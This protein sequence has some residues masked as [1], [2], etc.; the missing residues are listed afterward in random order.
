VFAGVCGGVVLVDVG[1]E[2]KRGTHF[3]DDV[4]EVQ[5]Q[6]DGLVQV[7]LRH[8]HRRLGAHGEGIQPNEAGRVHPRHPLRDLKRPHFPT[9]RVLYIHCHPS[10]HLPHKYLP[11][12]VLPLDTHH[13]AESV[14]MGG[15]VCYGGFDVLDGVVYHE[16]DAE[17][18]GLGCGGGCQWDYDHWD[19]CVLG[20]DGLCWGGT[21]FV[22][23]A[24][25]CQE[26]VP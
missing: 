13:R 1:V 3:R 21:C 15:D 18:E 25:Y 22:R 9:E 12:D 11:A 10:I 23:S 19:F 8:H 6:Q 5:G 16:A 17:G 20:N 2:R 26:G 7:P 14:A 24:V 4:G